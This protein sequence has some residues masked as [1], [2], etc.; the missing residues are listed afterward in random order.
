MN[1]SKLIISLVIITLMISTNEG[2]YTKAKAE[3]RGFLSP[4]TRFDSSTQIKQKIQ[5]LTP[6]NPITI[7]SNDAFESHGFAGS[8]S[9]DDPFRIEGFNITSS[10]NDLIIIRDTDVAF[11]ITD[12]YLNGMTTTSAGITLSNVQHGRIE[13][14]MITR[15]KDGLFVSNTSETIF[16]NNSISSNTE[17]GLFLQKTTKCTLTA[18]TIHSNKANGVHL[19]NCWNITI[20]NNT[21]YNHQ[22]GEF[23]QSSILLDNS[24]NTEI[25]NNLLFSNGHGIKLLKS[26]HHNI[27]KNNTIYN[28]QNHGIQLEYTTRNTISW[29]NISE[30]MG[31]GIQVTIGSRNNVIQFNNLVQNN[32]GKTQA[33]DNG[34]NNAFTY[35][36]WD[37]WPIS[38]TNNDLIIDN[39]YLIDGNA[40]NTDPYPLTEFSSDAIEKT[41]N[42]PDNS[43]VILF[44]GVVIIAIGGIISIGLVI[45]RLNKAEVEPEEPFTEFT[46]EKQIEIIKP[47]YNK[48]VVGIENLQTSMLPQ[49]EIVPLLEP[50]EPTT[51]LEFFPSDIKEDLQSGMKWRTISTLIEIAYQDPSDTNPAKLAQ[52]L[53]IPTSTLSKEIKKLKELQY[54]E[55]YVSPQVLRDGRY[56]SYTITQKGFNLLY[57]LKETL[58]V[59]ITRLQEKEGAFYI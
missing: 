36:Y 47:I 3:I 24:S 54:I 42:V 9:K 37:E 22:D 52:S 29:N 46:I 32:G 35:N 50:A 56:R 53:N 13:N 16:Q 33:L 2:H 15:C 40:N 48:L 21:I 5:S 6:T 44:L 19:K 58:K 55:S 1:Y 20:Q 49:P 34:T 41:Q 26:A 59:T 43:W 10:L 30:N 28:N 4:V 27:I 18:N 31:Y 39:P 11:L 51:L 8:G 23:T 7:T 38:D 12:N 17:F 25:N 57:T 45:T 14:N